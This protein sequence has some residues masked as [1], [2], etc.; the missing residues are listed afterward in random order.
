MD[1]WF[2]LYIL[3]AVGICLG[4]MVVL[5]QTQRT[6]G[7]FLF[8]VGSIL[9]FVFY[10]LRWFS[11]DSLRPTKFSSSTWPPVINMCPDFLSLYAKGNEKVCVDL[12]GVSKTGLNKFVDP[13]NVSNDAFVFNLHQKKNGS[14]R[15]R[16]LC[17]E[18]KN[19][20]VTWEGIYDGKE[21]LDPSFIPRA[22]G[23]KESTKPSEKCK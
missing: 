10:G 12:I 13:S 23:T 5:I 2:I 21:C 9:I 19:K 7:G 14:E 11:G 3:I 20:G 8:L 17:Q 6:L 15:L 18:C 16:A 4:G 22:D 1:Y